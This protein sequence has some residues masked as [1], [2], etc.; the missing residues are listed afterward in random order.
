MKDA[1]ASYIREVAVQPGTANSV[2]MGGFDQ[3]LNLLDLNRP[4]APYVQRLDMQ[5]TI[6]SVKWAEFHDGQ[7]TVFNNRASSELPPYQC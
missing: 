7:F 3:K 1:A 2:A 5:G 4:D 6:G